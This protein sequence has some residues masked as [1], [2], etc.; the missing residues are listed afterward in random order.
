M[1]HE[2][3]VLIRCNGMM[4]RTARRKAEAFTYPLEAESFF[5]VWTGQAL[6]DQVILRD[7]QNETGERQCGFGFDGALQAWRVWG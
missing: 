4:A 2:K 7:K 6:G 1:T 3:V 5:V